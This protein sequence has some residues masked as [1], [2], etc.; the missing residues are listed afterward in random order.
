MFSYFVKNYSPKSV[1]CYA[2]WNLFKGNGYTECGF[3]FDGF[4]GPDKFYY[5]TTA[6]TRI[7]RNPYK[8]REFK[9][10]VKSNKLFECYGAGSKRFIWTKDNDERLN[11]N[12]KL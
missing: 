8:Y 3:V 5:D 4:T 2:D 6:K 11:A 10:Q 7:A 1:I 9:E 12:T